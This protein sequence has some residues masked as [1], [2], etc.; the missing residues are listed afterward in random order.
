MARRLT[1]RGVRAFARGDFESGAAAFEAALGYDPDL[2]WPRW[3]LARLYL[4]RG[5]RLEAL[6]QY[7]SLQASLPGDLRP[8][9]ERET[10]SVTG[11][12][13]GM[14]TFIV[15]LADPRDLLERAT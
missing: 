4:R 13:E 8:V 12:G 14:D 11:R 3:N 2:L 6:A 15:P 9:L 5:Q 1:A 10:D 7:E